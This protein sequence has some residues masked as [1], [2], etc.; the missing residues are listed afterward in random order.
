MKK[1]LSILL[2][3]GLLVVLGITGCSN[4]TKVK[5]SVAISNV[6]AEISS[7]EVFLNS[8]KITEYAYLVAPA[9]EQLSEDPV[10]IFKDGVTGQLTDGENT[11]VISGGLEGNSEYTAVIAFKLSADEFYPEVVKVDFTT[12]DYVETVTLLDSYYDG[13]K[14]H[15]KVPQEVKDAKHA[16]RFGIASLSTYIDRKVMRSSC[17]ALGLL[18]NGQFHFM[19]DTTMV[20]DNSN[21]ETICDLGDVN[22]LHEPIS[23]GEPLVFTAGEFL[24]DTEDTQG[25]GINGWYIP[26]FDLDAYYE[27]LYGGGGFMPWSI[28]V[29]K[30]FEN[31]DEFWTG[32]FTRKYFTSKAPEVL[33]ANLDVE[34]NVGAVRGTINITPDENI[35]QYCVLIIA[36]SYYKDYI[37]PVIDN[38]ESLLQWFVSSYYSATTWGTAVYQG[39]MEIILEDQLY[40]EPE[41]DYHL[42]ITAMGDDKGTSQC[43]YRKDFSTTAKT[44]PAPVMEVTPIDN[45]SG[46]ESPYEVWFNVKCTSKD[47]VSAK[48]AANYEREFGMAFNGGATYNS[49][50]GS[51]NAF[52]VEEMAL[53]NS[54][55]GENISFSTMPGQTTVL[56]VLGYNDEDTPNTI[57]GTDY[58]DPAVAKKKAINEPAKAPVESS[59]FKDLLGDWTMS[60]DVAEYDYYSSGWVPAGTKS[61]KVS[62]V[63]GVSYPETL[64]ESVYATYKDLVGMSKEQVDALY[65]EFKTEMDEFNAMLKSQNRLLCYGFG[66]DNADAYTQYFTLNTPYDLFTSDSYN[67]YDNN[68]ML[69]DCGPKW[70]LEILEDGSVVAPVNAVRQ[71]PLN[72]AGYY[73]VYLAGVADAYINVLKDGSDVLFPVSVS[74]DANIVT[75]NP[76]IH[77]DTEYFLNGMYSNYGYMY[78]TNNKITSALTLTKGWTEEGTAPASVKSAGNAAPEMISIPSVNGMKEARISPAKRKTSFKAIKKYEKAEYSIVTRE[79]LEKNVEARYANKR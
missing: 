46:E 38:D 77:E 50:V 49:L 53:I 68:S 79:Q 10:V 40:L 52:S 16:I 5:S 75:V 22:S 51:G 11:I 57:E 42:F 17:D 25:W 78:P 61:C 56:A 7:A 21:V 13:I 26:A 12:T 15:F 4:E 65:D 18:Y 59:L 3:A 2:M 29:D 36:D 24:Y 34:V 62:I 33:E 54:D 45:P 58:S 19:N 63:E 73:T 39:P 8:T 64:D 27:A 23:P 35:Y 1:S 44:H 48:Y 28:E 55:E 67:G 14:L 74:D 72:L 6:T 66:F 70:Y 32:Y 71:Y 69:W 9:G 31:E 41:T 20:F 30:E 37:L 43:F 60:A 47:A 76:Y